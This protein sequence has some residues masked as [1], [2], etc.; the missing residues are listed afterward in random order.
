M[1]TPGQE[2]IEAAKADDAVRKMR[3]ACFHDMLELVKRCANDDAAKIN[4]RTALLVLRDCI[5][6]SGPQGFGLNLDAEPDPREAL[7][8]ELTDALKGIASLWPEQTAAPINPEWVGPNDG[9]M[10]A[11]LLEAAIISARAA[12]TKAAEF[13]E[14]AGTGK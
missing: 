4:G 13:K 14:K 3:D 8:K 1:N 7:I 2:G 9:K 5:L 10:R 6:E 11:I 12:L